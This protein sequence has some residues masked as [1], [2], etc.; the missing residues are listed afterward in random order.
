MIILGL[1]IIGLVAAMLSFFSYK[2]MI[3]RGYCEVGEK[4]RCEEIYA[5]PEKYTGVMGIHF[6]ILAPI[7]FSIMTVLTIL[8]LA[9]GSTTINYMIIIG[10]I[11]G[12]LFVPYLVYI[13][14]RIAHAFCLY[15]TIMH[16][17][18]LANAGLLLYAFSR[19]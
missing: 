14:A 6:S 19:S 1:Y 5:L 18:I 16:I 9:T 13:E 3:S 15:C 7:Y 10:E 2:N 4:F 11:I 8:F 12:V 17:I